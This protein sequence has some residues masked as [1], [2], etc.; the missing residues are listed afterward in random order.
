MVI[1]PLLFLAR[2]AAAHHVTF[3]IVRARYLPLRR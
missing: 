1:Y 3:P 2:P